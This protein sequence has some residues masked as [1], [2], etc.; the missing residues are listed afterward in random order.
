LP[1]APKPDPKVEAAQKAQA[2]A[3]LD[4]LAAE[5]DKETVAQRRVIRGSGVRS[6][7]G[8]GNTGSGYGTNA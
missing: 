3:E 7:L 8:E 4:R 5:K 1:K 6:L 2:Q